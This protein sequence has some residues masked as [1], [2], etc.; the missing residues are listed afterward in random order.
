MSVEDRTADEWLEF[1]NVLRVEL[2][3]DCKALIFFA[4]ANDD[5]NMRVYLLDRLAI[6][7][8]APLPRILRL[9]GRI[10]RELDEVAQTVTTWGSA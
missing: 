10:E 2:I 3:D 8:N 6:L 9:S 7:E 1:A 4:M 5:E